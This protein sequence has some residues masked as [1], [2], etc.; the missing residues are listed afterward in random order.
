VDPVFTSKI[1]QLRGTLIS[2]KRFREIME[3][4]TTEPRSKEIRDV[5]L[6]KIRQQEGE[7][8]NKNSVDSQFHGY[9]TKKFLVST[10]TIQQPRGTLTSTNRFR[11]TMGKIKTE[12]KNKEIQDVALKK[13]R[14]QEGGTPNK[15]SMDSQKSTTT[16]TPANKP[17]LS[18]SLTPASL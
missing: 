18:L 9:N 8:P 5:T 11:E 15:S 6:R 17:S 3:K 13:L 14:Q 10:S 4:I 7:P 12:P 1:Q 2:T 16:T